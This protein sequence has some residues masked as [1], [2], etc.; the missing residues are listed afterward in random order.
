MKIKKMTSYGLAF[1]LVLALVRPLF[2]EE[3]KSTAPT[4]HSLWK[5]EDKTN[6]L[7]LLGSIHLLKKEHYPLP[8]PI[9]A[10]YSNAQVAVFETEI[11]RMEQAETQAKI[12]AKAMLPEGETLK[13]ILSAETYLS[14]SN[15]IRQAGLPMMMFDRMR[16]G[17][18]AMTLEVLAMQEMGAQAELGLDLHFFKRARQDGKAVIG[19][20]SLDFQIALITDIPKEEGELI[21]K[22]TLRDMEKAKDILSEMISTWQHGESAKLE[23]L[24]N[25][26]LD[27]F[28]AISKRFLTD[29]NRQWLT[30]LD[31][32]LHADKTA[33]VIVG[34]G[35]LVG[36][37]G[38]VELLKKKGYKVTQL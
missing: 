3:V 21:L 11:D 6:S 37:E 13:K 28:P 31:E 15:R 35:H 2:A 26:S 30:K 27:E 10:A 14:F 16:P 32:L 23:T 8:L 22:A 9:E 5:V 34:A 12:L 20:E 4:L 1:G 38:V 17:L 29:R 18:A 36:K 24:L 7:Y 25:E 33:I 19:L